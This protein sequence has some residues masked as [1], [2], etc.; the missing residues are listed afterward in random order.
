MGNSRPY[1]LS[2]AG[3]DPSGGAGLLSDIKT[4]EN[5]E[6]MGLG[7]ATGITYQN[8]S[9]FDGMEWVSYLEI[10]SQLKPLL[11]KY[12]VAAVKI[13]IIKDLNTLYNTVILV[14]SQ[15]QKAFIVWDPVIKSTSGFSFW[16][17]IDSERLINV[18]QEINL[19]TPNLNELKKLGTGSLQENISMLRKQVNVLVKGGHADVNYAEDVLYLMSGEEQSIRVERLYNA[20]KHGTGCIFSSA[21][22]A[23]KAKGA[24]L[25]EA[26][27][28]AKAYV[29]NYL[30]ST[31]TGLG[32]HNNKQLELD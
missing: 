26:F 25:T 30:Q 31:G 11:R 8:E 27:E 13:G 32:I 15:F 19:I 6:V 4:F 29:F 22:A 10:E 1:V 28:Y 24:S 21:L 12:P 14:R 23:K 20:S 3:L 5:S 7:V 9:Q 2:I 16:K 18:L 17:N